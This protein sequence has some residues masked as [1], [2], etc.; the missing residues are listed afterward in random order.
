MEAG[1][2]K[3]RPAF[4][5][6]LAQKFYGRTAL[7][8]TISEDVIGWYVM[9]A[10]T[11]SLRSTLAAA[12]AWSMTDF[13]EEMKGITIPVRAIHGTAMPRCRS[14]RRA[15]NRPNFCRLCAGI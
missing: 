13:R 14:M 10:M 3:D 2:R 15:E 11:G 12:N 6:E 8:H 1:I 5:K 7:K 9:M 4:M